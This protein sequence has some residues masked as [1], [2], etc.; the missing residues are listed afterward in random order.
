MCWSAS[1]LLELFTVTEGVVLF[2]RTPL[3]FSQQLGPLGLRRLFLQTDDKP[4][5]HVL[6]F[7]S[8]LVLKK[9]W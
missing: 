4:Q 5:G 3:V 2:Q 7:I 8:Y 6:N 1:Q 9:L